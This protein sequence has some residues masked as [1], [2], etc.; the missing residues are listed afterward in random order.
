MFIEKFKNFCLFFTKFV[1]II[2][3]KRNFIFLLRDLFNI[4][5]D[6]F[7]SEVDQINM[8]HRTCQNCKNFIYIDFKKLFT[9]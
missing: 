2:I 8:S 5:G 3:T 6:L 1:L 9:V 4:E 7:Q